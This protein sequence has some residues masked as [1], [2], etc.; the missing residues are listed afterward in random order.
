MKRQPKQSVRVKRE[1]VRFIMAPDTTSARRVIGRWVQLTVLV[2][3][4]EIK[5]M[6]AQARK[7]GAPLAQA[8]NNAL[9]LGI[10]DTLSAARGI[11]SEEE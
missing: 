8:M 7:D 4:E 9:L 5:E 2:P 10:S 11:D 3:D 1:P 6:K